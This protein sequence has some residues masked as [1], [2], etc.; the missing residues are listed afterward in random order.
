[1]LWRLVARLLFK[2]CLPLVAIAGVLTYGVYLRG[3]DPGALWSSVAERSLGQFDR[4]FAGVQEDTSRAAGA[5]ARSATSMVGSG[6]GGGAR[7]GAR[8]GLTE[9]F[10]WKDVNGITHYS[11]S[12]P[13]GVASGTVARTVRVDPNTN[14]LAPVRAPATAMAERRDGNALGDEAQTGDSDGP[15]PGVAGQVLATRQPAGANPDAKADKD[16]LPGV[17]PAQLLRMLQSAGN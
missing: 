17:D 8:S 15:L 1:M 14:V 3:G 12:P 10:T 6:E 4:L 13:E 2:A 16:A 11:N 5:I 7:S 9:V